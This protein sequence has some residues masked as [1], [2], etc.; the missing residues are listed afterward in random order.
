MKISISSFC[1]KYHCNM[2]QIIILPEKLPIIRAKKLY[3]EFKYAWSR[4]TT[5]EKTDWAL[6]V[7]VIFGKVM[8]RRG[9]GLFKA[10]GYLAKRIFEEGKNLTVA[11][12]KYKGKEYII[13]RKDS[14]FKFIVSGVKTSKK[15]VKNIITLLKTNPKEAAPKLF[16]GFVG[17]IC[18]SG[19]VDG[20]GGI[21]DLDI[22]AGGIGNH[23]SIFF[24]S[25]IS[26][27]VLETIVFSSVK[28]V[29]IMYSK[30]PKEH[31]CFWDL[32]INKTDWAEAFVS[33]A[34]TGIAYHLLIDGTIQGNKAY[35][36]I[37]VSMT[38]KG[39]NTIFVTNAA[40][41]AMDLDNKKV[42]NI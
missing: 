39:H 28:A 9:R 5:Q 32:V 6:D 10:V 19:G 26:A 17:F 35:V 37:P 22:V 2:N 7:G 4:T 16:L 21:P 40:M 1:Y 33:G 8:L 38:I 29:N 12:F 23:R 36:D 41:E 3:E 11:I 31:D 30:L 13:N 15:V 27:A 24:H 34:C 25:V 42:K 18:G 20:N 14:A